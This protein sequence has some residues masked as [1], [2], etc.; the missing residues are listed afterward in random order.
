MLYIY[1]RHYSLKFNSINIKTE[2]VITLLAIDIIFHLWLLVYV[3]KFYNNKYTLFSYQ[4]LN[5]IS[6]IVIY[7]ILVDVYKIYHLRNKDIFMISMIFVVILL[8]SSKLI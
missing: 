2:N 3:I 7:C 6:L 8:L 4:T 1:P 5:S